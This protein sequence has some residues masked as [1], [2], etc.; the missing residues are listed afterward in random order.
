ML[1]RVTDVVP[2][3]ILLPHL[4]GRH[5][6]FTMHALLLPAAVHAA[7]FASAPSMRMA[8]PVMQLN[9]QQPTYGAAARAAARFAGAPPPQQQAAYQG[10]VAP[11]GSPPVPAVPP[12]AADRVI[13]VQGGSLTTW[14]YT[15]PSVEQVQVVLSTEGRPLDANVELWHGS[16]D[17]PCKM[18]VYVEDGQ[19]RP[20]TA[21]IATPRGPS[22]VA[23]RNVGQL[24]LPFDARVVAENVDHP[25]SDCLS[26]AKGLQGGASRSYTFDPSVQSVQVLLQTDGYPLNAR[27][28]LIQGPD[29]NRQV[30]HAS[31]AL[32]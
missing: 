16:G 23:I 6:L 17:I 24:E 5:R 15:S 27:I 9:P 30:S 2:E 28:E 13:T 25:S 22:T 10:V 8:S 12:P 19:L 18:R 1:L 21:V 7:L 11:T 26:S 29:T 32:I 3:N 4:R 20:F 14:R 31:A